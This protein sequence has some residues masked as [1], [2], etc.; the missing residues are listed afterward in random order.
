VK[1]RFLGTGTS[2][3]VPV[4]GC[5]CA[6]C[7]SADPRDRRTRHGALLESDDGRA[8]LVD[9]PPELRL[10]LLR[11]GI[12][13]VDAVWFTHAHADHVHGIDDLRVFASRRSRPLPVYAEASTAAQLRSRFDY[14]FD[15]TYEPPR[16]TSKPNLHLRTFTPFQPLDVAGF[17]MLPI[18][19]PHGDQQV[20]GFR[21]GTLGYV[22]DAKRLDDRALDA[23]RGVQQLVLNA[24][25]YGSPHPT[26]FNVEEAVD[27]ARLVG[28]RQTWLTH[29][30]HR[31]RHAE[32][33]RSLPAGVAPAFDGL[34]VD[35]PLSPEPSPPGSHHV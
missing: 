8:V 27:A 30:T 17:T 1:L 29:L 5:D 25:W 21:T 33:E 18:T 13:R 34:V 9:A 20:F 14:I 19:L 11:D 26:H 10:Q 23:L 3:G 12:R 24:L 15:D 35:V 31:V 4:V 28:A 22:T 32:L 2:F 6:T 7:T 16:G